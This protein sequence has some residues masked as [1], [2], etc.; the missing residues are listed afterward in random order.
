[1]TRRG[2]LNAFHL[3]Q[4]SSLLLVKTFEKRNMTE[5]EG[6]KQIEKIRLQKPVGVAPQCKSRAKKGQTAFKMLKIKILKIRPILH[7]NDQFIEWNINL[8]S[9]TSIRYGS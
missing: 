8:Y 9:R 3:L 6:G 5:V 4:V 1:M 2:M 7:L